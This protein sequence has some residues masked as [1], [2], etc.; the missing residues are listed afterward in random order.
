MKTAHVAYSLQRPGFE[1]QDTEDRNERECSFNSTFQDG[2]AL[3]TFIAWK[4][5]PE[6]EKSHKY[7]G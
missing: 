2:R 4:E 5:K 3:C 7:V 6:I 1:R